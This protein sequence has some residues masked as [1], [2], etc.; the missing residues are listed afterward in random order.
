MCLA[1]NLYWMYW[2]YCD[3][4]RL[5]AARF[6]RNNVHRGF[7]TIVAR[8]CAAKHRISRKLLAY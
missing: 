8:S 3:M 6:V 1:T 4:R 7:T 2:M 5:I